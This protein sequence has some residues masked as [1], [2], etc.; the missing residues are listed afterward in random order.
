MSETTVETVR[1]RYRNITSRINK[2]YWNINSETQHSLYVG[3]Y[4][5]GTSINTSDID[6]VVILPNSIYERY[7]EYSWNG[8]SKL[9][10]D[11]KVTLQKTY[12]N[13]S[14]KAD[15]QVIDIE[16][17]DDIKFEVVPAFKLNNYSDVLTYPDTNNGGIWKQMNPK[18]EIEAFNT[19]NNSTNGNLKHFCRMLRAWNEKNYVLL[20]GCNI[21]FMVYRFF[22]DNTQDFKDKGYLYYG[23]ISTSIFKYLTDNADKSEWWSPSYLYSIFPKY[24]FKQDASKAYEIA[25][26]AIR[27]END[28]SEEAAIRDWRKIYG[29]RFPE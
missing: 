1:Y 4:G 11:V 17:S 8:Q 9:L 19:V 13:S 24:S 29:F 27:Y 14:I 28:N 22:L 20:T 3:S 10:Q 2:E 7:N 16:F 12:P 26:E 5:R 25:C 21:D 6:I 23:L 15:G 18:R